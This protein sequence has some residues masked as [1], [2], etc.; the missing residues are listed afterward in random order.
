MNKMLLF[1]RGT[2]SLWNVLCLT[3]TIVTIVRIKQRITC[4]IV[5]HVCQA[6]NNVRYCRTCESSRE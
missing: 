2:S 4:A 5:G 6:E 3:I 1:S